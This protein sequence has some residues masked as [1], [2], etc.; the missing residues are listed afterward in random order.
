MSVAL[1]GATRFLAGAGMAVSLLFAAACDDD[2][3]DPFVP[4]VTTITLTSGS[5]QTV[6]R[7]GTS[8]PLTV[9]VKDQ[10][11]DPIAGRTVNWAVATGGGTLT[12]TSST[13]NAQ[14]VA[15]M[16]YTAGATAGAAT[17][18]A[19]VGNLTPVTFNI[20]IT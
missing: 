5:P 18:T 14:G 20:T 3:D 19:T 6:A 7:N 10:N 1:R 8:T 9:T 2:D 11:G 13:T 12:A 4:V 16:T 17:V 15:T